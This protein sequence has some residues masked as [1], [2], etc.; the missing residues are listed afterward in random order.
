MGA[1]KKKMIGSGSVV[2][3]SQKIRKEVF[4]GL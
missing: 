3:M 4:N 1:I 2:A